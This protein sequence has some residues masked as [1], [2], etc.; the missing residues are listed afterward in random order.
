[1]DID[2]KEIWQRYSGLTIVDLIELQR[3]DR[4]SCADAV[5]VDEILEFRGVSKTVRENLKNSSVNT[6][7][8]PVG[9]IDTTSKEIAARPVL[10]TLIALFALWQ[11]MS[12]ILSVFDSR[13]PPVF[14]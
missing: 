11:F 5:I 9:A 10:V 14:E 7:S 3:S 2:K 6:Q 8:I 13:R 4:L 1:M 12:N